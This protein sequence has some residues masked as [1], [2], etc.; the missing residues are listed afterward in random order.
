MFLWFSRWSKI[1]QHL[2]GRTDNEIKNYWRTRVQKQARQLKID[3]NSSRFKDM[4]RLLWMPRL[5]E[6]MT[7]P[8]SI[9]SLNP[10]SALLNFVPQS[11]P[12]PPDLLSASEQNTVTKSCYSHKS[13]SENCSPS[14]SSNSMNTTQL[15]QISEFP[16]SPKDF[17][18][19]DQTQLLKEYC[20]VD[21]SY[22]LEDLHLS[23]TSNAG[24]NYPISDFSMTQNT[25]VDG[26][27]DCL[28]NMDELWQFRKLQGRCI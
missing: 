13:F 11:Y 22:D 14:I 15:P 9:Q 17:G 19:I 4:I 28:W 20:Y 16:T 21:E 18:N 3:A 8:P 7:S 6:K 26:M 1:A 25:C 12:S 24:F 2:P 27:A 10:T 23:S 5:L